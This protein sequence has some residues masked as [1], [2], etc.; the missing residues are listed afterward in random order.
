MLALYGAYIPPP[1]DTSF[2]CPHCGYRLVVE[3]VTPAAS[4]HWFVASLIIG[5]TILLAAVVWRIVADMQRLKEK[6]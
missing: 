5:V 6:P 2:Q 3:A 1:P 4:H